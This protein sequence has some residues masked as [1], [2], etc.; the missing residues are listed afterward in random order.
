MHGLSLSPVLRTTLCYPAANGVRIY[1]QVAICHFIGNPTPRFLGHGS[2]RSVPFGRTFAVIT[3]LRDC[4]PLVKHTE[5]RTIHVYV[6]ETDT[7]SLLPEQLSKDNYCATPFRVPSSLFGCARVAT[8]AGGTG[9]GGRNNGTTTTQSPT[10]TTPVYIGD[11][12][13]HA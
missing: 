10:G 13:V 2:G 11:R 12:C 7:W 1:I 4:G 6:P 5:N 8:T 3:E 9:A